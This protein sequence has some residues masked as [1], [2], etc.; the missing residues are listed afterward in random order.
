MWTVALA[1]V[2][3]AIGTWLCIQGLR[4]RRAY[5]A[6]LRETEHHLDELRCLIRLEQ[7]WAEHR[8][9]GEDAITGEQPKL[10]N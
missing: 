8:A 6:L 10:V 7:H 9:A 5:E 2:I 3:V 4:S 1:L